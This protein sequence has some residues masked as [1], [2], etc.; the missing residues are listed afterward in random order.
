M[1]ELIAVKADAW[2]RRSL[3][4]GTP[5]Q[6]PQT[7]KASLLIAAAALALAATPVLAQDAH[8]PEAAAAAKPM[9][10]DK[11]TP[12]Q[13]HKHCAMAMGGKMQ[14]AQKHDH[15]ADKLGHAPATTPPTEAE[16][17]AMHDRCAEKMAVKTPAAPAKK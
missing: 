8:H 17:K 9:D 15:A 12:E 4:G 6:D 3:G 5:A 2:N 7:M 14:G 11:M 13:M 10:M 1:E 16:M